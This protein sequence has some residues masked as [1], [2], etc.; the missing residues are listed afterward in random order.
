MM[1]PCGTIEDNHGDYDDDD[2][3][4]SF[5][6]K[7]HG[8]LDGD[9]FCDNEDDASMD[10]VACNLKKMFQEVGGVFYD[11]D[12]ATAA[13]EAFSTTWDDN[14]DINASKVQV[15]K[16]PNMVTGN[17][18]I[19][20]RREQQ[21]PFTIRGTSN[22]TNGSQQNSIKMSLAVTTSTAVTSYS[23]NNTDTPEEGATKTYQKRVSILPQSLS[24]K[25]KNATCWQVARHCMIRTK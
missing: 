6:Y 20:A 18:H 7:I 23:S 4:D 24:M 11:A 15:G 19:D 2:D 5:Y 16:T 10:A 8:G 1:Q 13:M 3:D 21:P 12:D 14:D 25:R 22:N 9:P 17:D